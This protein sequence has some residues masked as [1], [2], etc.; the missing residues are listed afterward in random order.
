MGL[1]G[2]APLNRAGT[3][4]AKDGG[5][6]FAPTLP[7]VMSPTARVD[8]AEQE[9]ALVAAALDALHALG[10]TVDITVD[11]ASAR[12]TLEQA[13]PAYGPLD[14]DAWIAYVRATA[15]SVGLTASTVSFAIGQLRS[16]EVRRA[17]PLVGLAMA[18]GEARVVTLLEAG[19]RRF[20][21]ELGGE[22]RWMD[23]ASLASALGVGSEAAPVPWLIGRP[24]T[25]L[26]PDAH[27]H[28]HDHPTPFQRVRSLLRLERDDVGLAV[29]Y[30]AAVGIVSLIV[31]VSVQ[32][33]VNNV[34]F[35]GLLQPIVVLSLVVF[36]GLAL[37]GAL[38]GAQAWVVERIQ[39][40]VFA[41][42]V[43]DLSHRL[44]RVRGETLE[45]S[46]APELVNRFFDVLSV[47]K[48]LS[49]LLV[50]GLAVILATIVGMVILAFYHPILL[51]LDVVLVIGLAIVIFGATRSATATAID[52]SKAKYAV[53][54]WLEEMVRHP[55]AFKTAG[56]PVFAA[57]RAE[58]LLFRYLGAR[59]SHFKIVF[60]KLAGALGL[61]ALASAALLGLGGALVIEGKLTL[62]QLVAAEL[63]VTSVVGRFAKF[64]KLLETTYDLLAAVDKLGHLVD[65]PLESNRGTTIRRRPEGAS[66][67]IAGLTYTYEG[68]GKVLAGASLRVAP[69]RRVAL[70]GRNA[71]GKSTLLDVL[72]S[73]RAPGDGRVLIDDTDL[74]TIH[75]ESWREHVALVRDLEVFQ[76]TIR[77]N[78]RIGRPD[79]TDDDIRHALVA[80]DLWDDVLALPGGLDTELTPYAPE[81]SKGQA[82][83]LVL[84]RAVAGKP[85]LLMLDETLDV[86]DMPTRR[87]LTKRLFDRAAPWTVLITTG[88]PDVM[89]A[90]DEVVVLEGGRLRPLRAEDMSS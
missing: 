41:R 65:L 36:V 14:R 76:G 56:G 21:V 13:Q 7:D 85:R 26:S 50:D 17:L 11:R 59:S 44:P 57:S 23:L 35:G 55:M 5:V 61:Q 9:S 46:H 27:D 6:H 42:V 82:Y 79:V 32:A 69:G 16:A 43:V 25:P 71:S 48:S 10:E 88:D 51:G 1:H 90:A 33:L 84:A 52:E 70:I 22:R 87:A 73:L 29:L 60:T 37:A 63:I 66:I 75:P 4:F 74:R 24:L 81:L 8:R 58:D 30:A 67:E 2:S 31:P 77:E 38:T 80:A 47:Q 54:A 20:H 78:I 49:T 34:A 89:R 68:G 15:P 53:A 19:P 40:R 72:Y 86:L 18:E 83:R 39:R 12:R 3:R 45:A 62:G 28:H 64:G